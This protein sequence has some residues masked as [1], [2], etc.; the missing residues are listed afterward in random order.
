MHKYPR[1]P[2]LADS[3]RQ[4]GDEELGHAPFAGI[5][6]RPVV[7]TEKLDGANAGISFTSGGQLLLQSRGHYLT[8][9][10][11]ERQFGPLKSWATTV[12]P[13]LWPVLGDRYVLY[14]EWLYAK[15]TLFYDGLPH[16]FCAFDVLDSSTEEFLATPRRAELLAGTPVVDVPVLR[17]GRFDSIGGLTSLAGPSRFRTHHW[18]QAL[19]DAAQAAGVDPDRA[20]A[21]TDLSDQMEGLYVTVEVDGRVTE[22]YKW[23]RE[24][25][26][27]T[28]ADS[29]WPRRPI[30]ANRLADPASR[31]GRWSGRTL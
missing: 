21:E 30:I 2:H 15:H 28:G 24:S 5:R 4:P 19:A 18:R 22:R 27:Q 3:R 13:A 17:S 25:F 23:I 1:T 8:G 7:V 16:Y 26:R 9:G 29:N 31:S 10:P 6:G 12:A 20:A 11:R 14:G